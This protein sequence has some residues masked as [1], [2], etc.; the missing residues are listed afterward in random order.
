MQATISI[1]SLNYELLSL[2][3]KSLHLECERDLIIELAIPFSIS[4]SISISI[5]IPIERDNTFTD[6]AVQLFRA[7]TICTILFGISL[8]KRI[9]FVLAPITYHG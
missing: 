2:A 1:H 4:M 9:A 6:W 3:S 5:S 7:G 8:K